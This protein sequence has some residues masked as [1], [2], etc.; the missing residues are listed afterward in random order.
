[1]RAMIAAALLA[2]SSVL[3]GSQ[4]EVFD[5]PRL[6]GIEIDGDLRDW[7]RDRGYGFEI[8]LEESG[9][10]KSGDDHN[11][12]F[13]AKKRA[14][15]VPLIE[16]GAIDPKRTYRVVAPESI[17]WTIRGIGRLW[18]DVRAGSDVSGDGVL[19]E[20]VRGHE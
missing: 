20:L 11:R 14:L 17:V 10:P 1:M 8:L 3:A 2:A 16:P 9:E 19:R 12:H 6:D 7:G 18:T 5:I 15:T 4:P 13:R